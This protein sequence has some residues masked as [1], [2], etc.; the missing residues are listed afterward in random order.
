MV[1]IVGVFK[2]VSLL[3]LLS[4][5]DLSLTSFISAHFYLFSKL[6]GLFISSCCN[7][8]YLS[9]VSSYSHTYSFVIY[10]LVL[11]LLIILACLVSILFFT[12]LHLFISP[13][14]PA[15]SSFLSSL[16][17]FPVVSS[18][19][20]DLAWLCISLLFLIRLEG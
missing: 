11:P 6:R 20:S 2:F 1:Q 17:L 4:N 13:I 12:L 8:C 16:F 15:F 10:Y 3:F 19:C 5:L 9:T 18:G 7:L 14:L